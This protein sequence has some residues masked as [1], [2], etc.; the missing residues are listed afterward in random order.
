MIFFASF[1]AF[2]SPVQTDELIKESQSDKKS[3]SS[4]YTKY[5]KIKPKR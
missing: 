4:N 1:S 2:Y 3:L 5:F